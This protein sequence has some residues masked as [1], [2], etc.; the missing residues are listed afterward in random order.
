M[1]ISTKKKVR[2]LEFESELL[3]MSVQRALSILERKYMNNLQTEKD[4]HI[5]NDIIETVVSMQS[6][7]KSMGRALDAH[8][9]SILQ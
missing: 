5:Y 9:D 1:H 8:I 7:M 3:C 2:R 6:Q 4:E